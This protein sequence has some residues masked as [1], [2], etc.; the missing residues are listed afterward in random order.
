MP[1]GEPGVECTKQEI[2]D[3]CGISWRTIHRWAQEGEV[4]EAGRGRVW[5]CQGFFLRYEFLACEP[6][7]CDDKMLTGEQ[8]RRKRICLLFFGLT[9]EEYFATPYEKIFTCPE[10][11]INYFEKRMLDAAGT[12]LEER[13][14][15]SYEHVVEKHQRG[16]L[17]VSPPRQ[18]I[19]IKIDLSRYVHIASQIYFT[20]S[21]SLRW[22]C[23]KCPKEKLGRNPTLCKNWKRLEN[24]VTDYSDAK[25]QVLWA[26]LTALC[27][28]NDGQIITK[29]LIAKWLG[30]SRSTV[31]YHINGDKVLLDL[32]EGCAKGEIRDPVSPEIAR[33]H[34]AQP[35]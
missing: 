9:D 15:E 1:N 30:K 17:R 11:V 4:Y 32:Y 10:D 20:D 27:K 28:A 6:L 33:Q 8:Q 23:D 2:A 24:R 26:L 5:V 22:L 16:E 18:S 14:R 21:F 13:Q 34:I 12:D 7:I 31:S 25:L 3:L 35:L 29:S 19:S